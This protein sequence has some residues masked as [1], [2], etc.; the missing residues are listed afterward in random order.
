MEPSVAAM[1]AVYDGRAPLSSL[2]RYLDSA[3]ACDTL[4][5]RTVV[6]WAGT[7]HISGVIM[8]KLVAQLKIDLELS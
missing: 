4:A 7:G 3:M 1:T 6:Q 8:D 5:L 2:R